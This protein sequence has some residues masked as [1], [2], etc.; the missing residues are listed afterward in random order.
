MISKGGSSNR[1]SQNQTTT[2]TGT[3]TGTT[4]GTS[5]GTTSGT[6]TPIAPQGWEDM[7]R[8]AFGLTGQGGLTPGQQTAA[9]YFTNQ[10]GASGQA[11]ATNAALS[12]INTDYLLPRTE[13]A[14]PML[15]AAPTVQGQTGAAYSAPYMNQYTENVVDAATNDLTNQYQ[16]A[17]AASGLQAAAGGAFGGSR[18]GVREAQVTDDYLRNLASTSANTRFG[19]QNA[20]FGF[21]QSDATRNQEAQNFNANLAQQRDLANQQAEFANRG[22]QMGALGQIIQNVGQYQGNI[23]NQTGIGS[24]LATSL[25]NTGGSGLSQFLT[26]LNAGL[27]LFGQQNQGTT[28]GNT[29]GT[30]TGTTSGTS[31]TTGSSSSS[32]KNGGI[33]ICWVAREVY[34]PTGPWQDFRE[35]LLHDAPKWLLRL[36]TAHGE[37]FA[38]WLRDKPKVKRVVKS[39][40]DRVI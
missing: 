4:T 3:S 28:T 13:A 27:P 32:G 2:A 20:A 14:T 36:Y 15:G 5:T 8:S 37:A 16:R 26:T 33:S 24:G 39:L 9:N 30:T 29:S 17:Q 19:A 23:N 18:Q 1:G 7:W 22:Q 10:L 21:G 38:E 11:P 6:A 12:T 31:N 35:W 40:M 34:G 25:F